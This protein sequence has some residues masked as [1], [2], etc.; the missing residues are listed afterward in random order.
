MGLYGSLF[1]DPPAQDPQVS[2]Q[3]DQ[4]DLNTADANTLRSLKGIGVKLAQRIIENRKAN[5]PFTSVD[6]LKRVKGIGSKT[7]EKNRDRMRVSSPSSP[8][9][10]TPAPKTQGQ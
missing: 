2:A 9:P 8:K 6:D 10:S 1:A 4:I 3:A 7:V 5:G